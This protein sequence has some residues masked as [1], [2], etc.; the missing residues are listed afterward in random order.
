LFA[1]SKDE[2]TAKQVGQLIEEHFLTAGLK[3]E[4]YVSEIN[5]QGA[6]II[7]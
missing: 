1:L 7:G 4:S 6:K 2:H 3:S 5:L